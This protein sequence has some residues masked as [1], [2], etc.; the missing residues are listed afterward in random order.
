[1]VRVRIGIYY[2]ARDVRDAWDV[3]V[4]FDGGKTFRN[5]GRCEGPTRNHGKY[6]VLAD[7][8][9]GTKAALVRCSGTQ[10]NTTMIYNLRISAAYREPHGGFLP[11]KVTYVWQE[12]GAEKRRVYVAKTPNETF[13]IQCAAKPVMKSL[14]VELAE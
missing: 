13:H 11:V 9:P 12:A 8:P 4:S 1:M 5:V 14:V 7:V 2:R 3:Q 6:F 10:R